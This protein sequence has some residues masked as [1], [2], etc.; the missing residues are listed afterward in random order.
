MLKSNILFL[1]VTICLSIGSQVVI[2]SLLESYGIKLEDRQTVQLAPTG[3]YSPG[4]SMSF[5][6]DKCQIGQVCRNSTCTGCIDNLECYDLNSQWIC[7]GG[8][9]TDDDGLCVHKTLFHN[10]FTGLD[11]VG[12][13]L[14]F[15]GCALSSGGGVGGG[16]IYIPVLILVSKWDPKSA[17]PLS[18]CLVAGCALANL[19]QNFSRRHPHTDRHLIDYSVAL[20]I[21]PLTLAGTIFGV[22]L[23]T[24][25]PPLLI[26]LLLVVTLS[27]TAYKTIT[28][29]LDIAKAEK[30]KLNSEALL[31]KNQ[32][33]V[34]GAMEPFPTK[35]P[36]SRFYMF[37]D[38]DWPKICILLVILTICTI[39]SILKG[40]NDEYSI[41]GVRLCSPVYWVLSFIAVPLIIIAWVFTAKYL[42]KESN[43]KIKE[44]REIEGEIKYTKK[45]I[46]ILGFLS[47]IAGCLASLLGI[48]G[49]MIK[50]PVLLQMGLSPD[51]TA[52]TSS[53]MILFTS[54]SSA[55]QY[56]LVGKLRLDYGVVYYFIGFISC[57]IGTQTLIWVVNKYKR[58]SYIVFLIGA[59]IA[60]ST[61]L[62]CVTEG[63]DFVKYRN[64]TFDSICTPAAASGVSG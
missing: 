57:F 34:N 40:G 21:E 36:R 38:A 4:E 9:P 16:G 14:L 29:G 30:K 10:E 17:I 26:L 23:H 42:Y 5:C 13:I 22:Y 43:L 50:G 15:I 33:S 32:S 55:I 61:V 25:F 58:R 27:F 63:I 39:F 35:M 45:N 12:F 59:V 47:I 44:G 11:M 64:L 3:I 62:L 46:V 60:V 31:N 28:K 51:V 53:Y 20:L 49:G 54:A 6:H 8:S 52:A 24:L 41:A 56:I 18:N 7:S 2:G 19:I 37:Y 48:G 1:V